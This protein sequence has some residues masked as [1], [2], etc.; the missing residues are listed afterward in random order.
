MVK[1]DENQFA[2]DNYFLKLPRKT[3]YIVNI[4]QKNI[5]HNKLGHEQN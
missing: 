3:I 1:H 4:N 2:Y 5:N